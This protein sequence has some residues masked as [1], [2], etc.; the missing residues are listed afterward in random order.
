MKK[1]ICSIV[2]GAVLVSAFGFTAA[3]TTSAASKTVT[4]QKV[5]VILPPM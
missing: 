5:E 2:L 1:I 4:P 3:G